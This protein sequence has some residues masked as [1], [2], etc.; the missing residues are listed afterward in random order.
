MTYNIQTSNRKKH[1]YPHLTPRVPQISLVTCQ[2]LLHG[3]KLLLTV[4]S[5]RSARLPN[6]GRPLLLSQRHLAGKLTEDAQQT[7]LGSLS[8]CPIYYTVLYSM[9]QTRLIDSFIKKNQVTTGTPWNM[10]NPFCFLLIWV[11]WV[12]LVEKTASQVPESPLLWGALARLVEAA[13]V[14]DHMKIAS[15]NISKSKNCWNCKSLKLPDYKN[16]EV[17]EMSQDRQKVTWSQP[18]GNVWGKGTDDFEKPNGAV[19]E[20]FLREW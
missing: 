13:M 5:H 1:Q 18:W 17:S 15:K 16:M 3:K 10:V 9:Y 11:Y 20:S 8:L 4:C 12:A 7:C 6:W 19:F 14:S 2:G